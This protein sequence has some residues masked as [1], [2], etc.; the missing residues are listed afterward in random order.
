MT[1]QIFEADTY[2][3]C[4]DSLRRDDG[5][6]AHLVDALA[7]LRRS[8]FHN[9]K[10]RTHE[11]GS[12]TNGRKLFSSDV[13]W[14][15]SDRRLV[16]QVFN[17]TIVVLLYGPH[18]V[19][20]RARR[21]RVDF[22]AE[23][24]MVQVYE[25]AVEVAA[26]RPKGEPRPRAGRLFMAWTDGAL[27]EGGLPGPAVEHLRRLDT[28]D[29]LFALEAELGVGNLERAFNLL[30]GEPPPRAAV[31]PDVPAA[32]DGGD[33]PSDGAPGEADDSKAEQPSD[34]VA[35][36][37]G[38]TEAEPPVATAEDLELERLLH[39]EQAGA[40]FTRVEPEFLADVVGRPIEDW[41]VFLPA[42]Q[43]GAATRR[44]Q[45]PARVRGAAG[46]GKTV[47]GLHRAADLALRNRA[48]SAERREQDGSE[49]AP[50]PPVLF[51]TYIKSL[52]P[53]FASLYERLPG[54]RGGEV[55]FINVDRLARRICKEAGDSAFVNPTKVDKAYSEAFK[56][57]VLADTPL[58]GRFTA[59]YLRE[60]ITKMIKGRAIESLDDYLNLPRTGR[61]AQL[62]HLQRTQV[63][64]LMECWD[65]HMARHGTIDFC[66]VILRALAHARGRGSPTYSAV[67]VD[68]AQDLTLAGLQLLRALVNAPTFEED[69]P[70][71]L[72]ILGDAAQRIY[73]GG[74][75]L[76]QAGVEVR[77]RTTLLTENYRNTAEIIAAAMA[78]AGDHRIEDLGE[79]LR[80][81]D[82][83][84]ATVRSGPRPV[85]VQISGLDA[86]TDEIARRI[87]ALGR[88]DS[89]IGPGDVAVLAPFNTSA[90]SVRARLRSHGLEVQSLEDYD[91]RH[92]DRVKVGTYH[93]AKGL[94]FKAVFLP[95]LGRFPPQAKKGSSA[96]E[97][98]ENHE[99]AV[100]QLFVAMT[101]A[102]DLVVV[103]HGSRLSSAITPAEGH[104]ERIEP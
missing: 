91:G 37:D 59:D 75:T 16:W 18:K 76:R 83:P 63:W 43:R 67:I 77:G 30:A 40:S 103:L 23:S 62:G 92:N 87:E 42:D 44:Y 70:D 82:E 90:N 28:V 69:R 72:F 102:R 104:F 48:I 57:I 56:Q 85:L 9:P 96:E 26:D 5:Y 78:V 15:G 47:V 2:W 97:A 7:E 51:T 14:R 17:R 46:T 93:R 71:G 88:S 3:D 94:E 41:M 39:D 79:D 89:G 86:Q 25:Q 19:Q 61:R 6:K 21:M 36:G 31:A 11:I 24:R 50:V 55:E 12:A 52:P 27:L 34:G 68:E 22:H 84:I 35:M 66:D 98:A 4:I 58:H 10:L 60:E 32:T 33:Q 81:G 29:E 100:S 8:P 13:G 73:P 45:G 99:L 65:A 74:F 95:H 49:A 54:T 80:R 38:D 1:Y 53:V 101:R 64:Q 20:D